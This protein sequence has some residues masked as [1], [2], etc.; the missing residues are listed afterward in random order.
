MNWVHSSASYGGQ[1]RFF[2][3][4][5]DPNGATALTLGTYHILGVGR[6]GD[7]IQLYLDGETDG[8]ATT[9]STDLASGDN[10]YIGCRHSSGGAI[11]QGLEGEIAEILIW[12]KSLSAEERA[13]VVTY[14][15][16]KWLDDLIDNRIEPYNHSNRT[17]LGEVLITKPSLR[18]N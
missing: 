17:K 13:S 4:G 9:N 16:T 11:Q 12:K 1:Q 7:Q 2:S 6:S 8:D 10:L 14:L 15:T 3:S 5:V 18:S